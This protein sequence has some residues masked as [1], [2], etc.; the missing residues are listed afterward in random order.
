[1]WHYTAQRCVRACGWVVRGPRHCSIPAL[2][3]VHAG[4][5]GSIA[6]RNERNRVGDTLALAAHA[7]EAQLLSS[8]LS[9]IF[10]RILSLLKRLLLGSS[11]PPPSASARARAM[12]P[13]MLCSVLC[14]VRPPTTSPTRPS[15]RPCTARPPEGALMP[16]GGS[17][18]ASR[19]QARP[20]VRQAS[21]T[22]LH[23]PPAS[24]WHNAPT[25]PPG[26]CRFPAAAPLSQHK[27]HLLAF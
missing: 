7:E 11:A 8:W 21:N 12:Q 17:G 2:P 20:A 9:P 18:W 19:Q 15:R 24:P 27:C 6:A 23:T 1:M 13:A 16:W 5:C 4:V 3:C 25:H 26:P 10:G 22:T 14:C